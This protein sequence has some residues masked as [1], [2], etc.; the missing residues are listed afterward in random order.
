VF[1]GQCL[2]AKKVY[3][4]ISIFAFKI[5]SIQEIND[6][7]K[8]RRE[9]NQSRSAQLLNAGKNKEAYEVMRLGIGLPKEIVAEA[10]KVCLFRI[11]FVTH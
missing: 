3:L 4:L 7:R 8:V 9:S 2:P 6:A 5:C 11:N 10:I 1:D